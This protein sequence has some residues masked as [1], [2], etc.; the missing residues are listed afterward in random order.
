MKLHAMFT[1]LLISSAAF[2][3]E[4]TPFELK[5]DAK[6]GADHYAML[7]IQC[8][9]E[10]GRGDGPAAKSVALDPKPANF[11]D[12]KNVERLTPE[13]VYEVIRDGGP[14]H[15]KSALM[16]SWRDNLTDEQIRNVA[17][18]VLLFKPAAHKVKK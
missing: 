9:G 5:G 18:Y 8:H 16:V 4:S 3:G 11:A 10:K 1:T 15:G 12:P 2:A 6:K 17:A 13:Y 14:S 7:C